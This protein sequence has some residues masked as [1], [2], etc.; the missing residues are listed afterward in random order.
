MNAFRAWFNAWKWCIEGKGKLQ[1]Q[2]YTDQ[3][4]V[5]IKRIDEMLSAW[6]RDQCGINKGDDERIMKMFYDGLNILKDQI[7]AG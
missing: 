1:D 7:I 3:K 5:G 4:F 6:V 2:S